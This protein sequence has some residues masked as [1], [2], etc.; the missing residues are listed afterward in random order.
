MIQTEQ[1]KQKSLT[2]KIREKRILEGLELVKKLHSIYK[3]KYTLY[4]RMSKE[5]LDDMLQDC[6]VEMIR[7]VDRFDENRGVKLSTYLNPR[8]RGSLTDT[9]RKLSKEIA[10][11]QPAAMDVSVDFVCGEID[12]IMSLNKEQAY[13]KLEKLNLSEDHIQDILIDISSDGQSYEIFDS[14]TNLPD[15]RIYIILGYY[16]MNKSIKEISKELGFNPETGWI[17]RLKREGIVKLKEL[18]IDKKILKEDSL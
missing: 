13:I 9:L 17:Y 5:D 18:L 6:T 4:K 3:L 8:I 11:R 14:L 2:S 7:A 15:V 1:H 16:I 12:N 10:M